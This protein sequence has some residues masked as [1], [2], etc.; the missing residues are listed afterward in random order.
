MEHFLNGYNRRY[1]KIFTVPAKPEGAFIL[2]SCFKKKP[3]NKRKKKKRKKW[4]WLKRHAENLCKDKRFRGQEKRKK[5]TCR[6]RP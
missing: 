1:Q 6:G 3:I 2:G 5:L 4:L